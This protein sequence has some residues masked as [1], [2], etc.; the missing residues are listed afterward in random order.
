[1]Y[2]R[3]PLSPTIVPRILEKQVAQKTKELKS[4]KPPAFLCRKDGSGIATQCHQQPIG[5]E[6][7]LLLSLIHI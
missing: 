1:M 6:A 3:A 2:N 7:G 4:K 5:I